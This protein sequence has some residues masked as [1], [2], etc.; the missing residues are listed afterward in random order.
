ML[1]LQTQRLLL[2]PW[3]ASEAAI[4]YEI[5]SDPIVMQ[6]IGE[7]KPMP[8]LDY[9]EA[10]IFHWKKLM[11]QQEG[12][13]LAIVPHEFPSEGSAS[14]PIGTVVLKQLPDPQGK[15]T[16]DWEMGWNLR[17]SAWGHGYA[18]EAARSLMTWGINDLELREIY[19]VA[20][21][22]NAASVR[23]MQRLGMKNL[24][25]T[26]KYYEWGEL[27]LYGLQAISPD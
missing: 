3:D 16:G 8:S 15:P 13:Y 20:Q 24:G 2:R 25:R 11:V 23:V 1:Q 10:K 19:A 9:T 22:I 5:Y 27:V 17:Q 26:C 21:P 4:A 18:T 6:Y 12:W 14:Q 7:G